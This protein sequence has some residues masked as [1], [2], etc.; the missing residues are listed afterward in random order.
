MFCDSG[1]SCL[2][3]P[4]L[5][6]DYPRLDG[7]VTRSHLGMVEPRTGAAPS[8]IGSDAE[9][10]PA[11]VKMTLDEMADIYRFRYS[12]EARAAG[13]AAGPNRS[14]AQAHQAALGQD[15][16]PR[17]SARHPRHERCRYRPAHRHS[18]SGPASLC[19]ETLPCKPGQDRA[20]RAEGI[21]HPNCT[22]PSEQRLTASPCAD[23][24][25]DKLRIPLTE[26][27]HAGLLSP[28]ACLSQATMRRC[29]KNGDYPKVIT[30]VEYQKSYRNSRPRVRGGD[31]AP[32]AGVPRIG[33][34]T[35]PLVLVVLSVMFL[36]K[37]VTFQ[38]AS[39]A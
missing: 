35:T 27:S 7:I 8:V 26:T 9:Q 11:T 24:A 25:T 18:R 3:F 6:D 14:G 33:V 37:A 12:V 20:A 4:R 1:S 39:S 38:F 22:V 34:F 31:T 10:R 19:C 36:A 13:A 2:A 32:C 21:R 5:A 17:R 16:G 28:Q 29:T 23:R 30:G 15:Q